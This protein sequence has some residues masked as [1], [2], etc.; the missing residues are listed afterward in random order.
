MLYHEAR[1]LVVVVYVDDILC[2][3]KKEDIK[4][5]FKKLEDRFECKES[6]W[7]NNNGVLFNPES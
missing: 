4:W 2:H 5:F 7:L 6:E 1:D 3:G